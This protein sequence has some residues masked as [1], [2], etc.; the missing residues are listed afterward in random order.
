M[1]DL[2]L[3]SVVSILAGQETAFSANIQSLDLPDQGGIWIYCEIMDGVPTAQSLELLCR[4]KALADISGQSL[5]SFVVGCQ[6]CGPA[7]Q[8]FSYGANYVHVVDHTYLAV[9]N[10]QIFTDVSVHLI[11]CYSPDILLLPSSDFIRALAPRIAARLRTGLTADCHS[12]SFDSQ[13]K[14]LLQTRLAYDGN[15]FATIV[16][17][18]TKPQMATVIP[19]DTKLL[20][21]GSTDGLLV[22]YKINCHEDGT[23]KVI[24]SQQNKKLFTKPEVLITVGKGIGDINN[25]DYVYKLS[26][27]LHASV[28]ATRGAVERG[29][30]DGASLIGE[31]GSIARGVELAILIG[32][33]GALQHMVGIKAK[34]I[35]AVNHDAHA[36][37][38]QYANYGAC[39][40]SVQFLIELIR[41]IELKRQAII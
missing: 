35:I 2:S 40:D 11:K 9:K 8:L 3:K 36:P 10:E 37:V 27:L 7:R 4:G 34:H 6:V 23:F 41:Q 25:L 18:G 32:V 22:C 16:C 19:G 1:L 21:C 12:L 28:G 24:Q 38:F 31:S 13:T 15:M 26:K 5:H 30:L 17:K 33:S 20:S 39:I 29:W 14:H